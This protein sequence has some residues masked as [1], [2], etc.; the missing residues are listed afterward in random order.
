MKYPST[1]KT[2]AVHINNMLSAVESLYEDVDYMILTGP[3]SSVECVLTIITEFNCP[4]KL[5]IS[6][7]L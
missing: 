4:N 6:P 2:I 1:S 5:G 7:S 3:C